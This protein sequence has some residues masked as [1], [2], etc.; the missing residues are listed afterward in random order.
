MRTLPRPDQLIF[1]ESPMTAAQDKPLPLAGFALATLTPA[2]LLAAG[3]FWGGA[4]LW[5]GTFYI[6]FLAALI[7]QLIPLVAGEAHEGQEF[8][9]SD[10]LLGLIGLLALAALPLAAWAIAG[11]SELGRFEKLLLFIGIGHWLGQVGHPAAHELIHRPSRLLFRL[12][13]MVYCW[14]F[15]GQHA[16]AHR[17]VHHRFVATALDPNSARKGES[18]YRFFLRAWR[19]SFWRGFEAESK[20][21]RGK[22]G[23]KGLHPYALY[24]LFYLLALSLAYL[25]A[26]FGGLAVWL[27]LAFQGQVQILVSDYVQ[28]YGLRRELLANGKPEP[29][30]PRHSWNTAQWFS[31]ALMLNAPRHSDHHAHPARGYPALRLG[32]AEE[33]PRLPWSLPLACAMAFFP[34]LW[35]RKMKRQL[36]KYQ[37]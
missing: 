32:A 17:L 15:F 20:L 11:P 22:K 13:Q 33:A 25:I 27:G 4:W 28:H 37:L 31:S 35:K 7:D 36:K 34:R 8:P 16:S 29:V 2:A 24:A 21:R 1:M 9:G 18:F 23:G 10:L 3:A 14:L 30:G 26:G 12:G 6:V 5:L 19:G